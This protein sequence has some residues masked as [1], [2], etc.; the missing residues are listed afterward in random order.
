MLG[1]AFRPVFRFIPV[2]IFRNSGFSA[3][4]PDSGGRQSVAP[5]PS[6]SLSSSPVAIVVIVIVVSRRAVAIVVVF[7]RRR[8][9][10]SS[11]SSPVAFVGPPRRVARRP[12]FSASSCRSSPCCRLSPSSCR[13]SP[14][15]PLPLLCRPW[16]FCAD[17]YPARSKSLLL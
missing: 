14:C 2:L 7:G 13:M 6:T 9:L 4:F 10:W 5:S 16:K 12:R 11:P 17:C 3:E 15:C 1:C 8:R